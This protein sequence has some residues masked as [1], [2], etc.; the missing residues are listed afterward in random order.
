MAVSATQATI[1]T[2]ESTNKN[3]RSKNLNKEKNYSLGKENMTD[4]NGV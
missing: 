1:Q 4:F 2:K 3:L